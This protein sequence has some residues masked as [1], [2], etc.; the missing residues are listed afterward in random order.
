[1][2]G[3]AAVGHPAFLNLGETDPRPAPPRVLPSKLDPRLLPKKTPAVGRIVRA[4]HRLLPCRRRRQMRL[5]LEE[6]RGLVDRPLAAVQPEAH[7]H[8][9]DARERL[10]DLCEPVAR[11]VFLEPFVFDKL[12][13]VMSPDVVT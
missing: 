2:R 4:A 3:R 7:D 1:R 9:A 12:H 8:P 10:A 5:V 6:L 11:I 13:S